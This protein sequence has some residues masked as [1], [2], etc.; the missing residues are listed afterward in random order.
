MY[1]PDEISWVKGFND[2]WIVRE[3]LRK[4]AA[5]YLEHLAQTDPK[6]LQRSCRRVK[7]LT[8]RFGHNEDPKPWFY[9][10]LFSLATVAEAKRYLA[11]HDFT[12]A[13]IPRLTEAA[14]DLLSGGRVA[15]TTSEKIH[16]IRKALEGLDLEEAGP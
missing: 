1:F 12:L 11:E 10:A 14:P 5:E 3:A 8:D 13:A 16:R 4:H 7:L 6:R 2:R 15:L 9:A